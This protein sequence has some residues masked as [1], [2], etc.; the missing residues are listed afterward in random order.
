M[1]EMERCY[2]KALAEYQSE[3]NVSMEADVLAR[4]GKFYVMC[5]QLNEATACS[6]QLIHVHERL[7]DYAKQLQVMGKLSSL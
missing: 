5:G 1:E 2:S 4:L 6:K 7:G 3:D